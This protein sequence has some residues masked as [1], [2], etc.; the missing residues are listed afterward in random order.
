MQPKPRKGIIILLHIIYP[1][2]FRKNV[3]VI[4]FKIFNILPVG[5]CSLVLRAE[6]SLLFNVFKELYDLIVV[7]QLIGGFVK[8][9]VIV[10]NLALTE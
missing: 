3:E 2:K 10:F 5:Y 9:E 7:K 1:V 6:C 8:H 4:A